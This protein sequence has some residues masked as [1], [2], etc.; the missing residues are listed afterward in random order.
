MTA[1][2]FYRPDE[3]LGG[4]PLHYKD[5][6]LDSIF[7]L[8]GFETET[9]DGE[10]YV[11]IKDIDGLHRAIGLH[12][13]MS[14]KAPSGKEVRFLRNEM[15]MSQSELGS[16]LGVTDQSVARWEKGQTEVPGPATFALKVLYLISLIPDG[17][18]DRVISQFME[19]L[20]RLSET[21]EI[22]DHATFTYSNGE[23]LDRAA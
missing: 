13:I 18:R 16:T 4:E 14:R 22:S 6:G 5:C 15:D 10:E 3:L 21:D 23:W 1:K 11:T 17:Q 7:L 19:A 20:H 9:H 8:N 2:R 12:I